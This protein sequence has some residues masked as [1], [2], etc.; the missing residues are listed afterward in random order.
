MNQNPSAKL[1]QSS[2]PLFPSPLPESK[3]Y[4]S[5][6]ELF[7]HNFKNYFKHHLNQPKSNHCS[8]CNKGHSLPSNTLFTC[9]M[10]QSCTHQNCYS[11]ELSE[12]TGS[13]WICQRCK[14]CLENN[15]VPNNVR[16]YL[17]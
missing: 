15:M 4:T 8:I 7:Q 2:S 17:E 5:D 3:Q 9:T 1:V 16:Y 13:E 10:C 6:K 11:S 12:K 14:Y